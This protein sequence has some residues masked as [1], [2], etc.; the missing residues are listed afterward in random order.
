MTTDLF[1]V[2]WTIDY[3]Y[4]LDTESDME[5]VI[6]PEFDN[7]DVLNKFDMFFSNENSSL[8]VGKRIFCECVGEWFEKNGI[9]SYRIHDARLFA[10]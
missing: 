7:D 3:G 5:A 9:K 8:I 1:M 2:F 6:L 4:G 10:K